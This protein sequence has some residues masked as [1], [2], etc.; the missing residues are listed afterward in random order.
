MSLSDPPTAIAVIALL[1]SALSALYT[2]WSW[3]QAQRANL[4]ALHPHQKIIYDG[5]FDLKA[6]MTQSGVNAKPEE[7]S[8]FYYLAITS[9][10]YFDDD[11]SALIKTYQKACSRVAELTLCKPLTEKEKVERDEKYDLVLS[12]TPTIQ[13]QL[14]KTLSKSKKNG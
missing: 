9:N 7:V 13:E 3:K 1:I 2:R 14:D 6:H 8:K 12:L 4:I 5:F 11:L 10:L